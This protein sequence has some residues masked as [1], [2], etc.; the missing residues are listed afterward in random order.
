[1]SEQDIGALK[2]QVAKTVRILE[3]IGLLDMNGH[4]SCRVPGTNHFLINCRQASRASIKASEIVMCDMEGKLV[5]GTMEPPSEYHIHTEIY[6]RRSDVGSVI[7]GHPHYQAVLGIADIPWQPVFMLGAAIP[8]MNTWEVS[9]LVNTAELGAELAEEIGSDS[10]IQIRHHGNVVAEADVQTAFATSVYAEDHA[11]KLYE[12]SATNRPL[13]VLS[14]DNLK[15]T[16]ETA[17]GPK[18]VKKVWTYYEEK[19]A[20]Q[21]VLTDI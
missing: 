8:R 11:R 14:G 18:I 16:A 19:A 13:R 5:E 20:R 7:H 1:M 6:K 4:V 17:W 21:G 12:A 3:S 9:S 15:R 2:L 10:I